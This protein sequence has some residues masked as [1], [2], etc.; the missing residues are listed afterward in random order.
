MSKGAALGDA[1]LDELLR[2]AN[3][4]DVLV[5]SLKP[6]SDKAG[7]RIEKVMERARCYNLK[8]FVTPPPIRLNHN[9]SQR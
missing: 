5:S 2:M 9:A 6:L 7:R 1:S 3:K 4:M 8:H